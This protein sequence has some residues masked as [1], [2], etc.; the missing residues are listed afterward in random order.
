M[1]SAVAVS[2]FLVPIYLDSQTGSFPVSLSSTGNG[3]RWLQNLAQTGHENQLS[4]P[5]LKS[6]SLQPR[7]LK[8]QAFRK[9][10]STGTAMDLMSNSLLRCEL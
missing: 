5:A 2:K 6:R 3:I 4:K 9:L 7:D 1:N 8:V 10:E